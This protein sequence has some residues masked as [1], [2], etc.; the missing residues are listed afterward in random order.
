MQRLE[1]PTLASGASHAEG[2]KVHFVQLTCE[3]DELFR[4]ITCDSRRALDKL[5]DPGRLT[6]LLDRFDMVSPAPFDQHLRLDVTH[7]APSESATRIIQ[8]YG[9]D[10]GERHTF[11]GIGA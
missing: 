4:R 5:G 7:V 1:R 6:D 10:N 8:H 9:I 3:R 11:A 2:G